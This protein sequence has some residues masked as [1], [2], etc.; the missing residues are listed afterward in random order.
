MACRDLNSVKKQ[1]DRSQLVG[2]LNTVSSC[3]PIEFG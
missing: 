1:V 3:K 2:E